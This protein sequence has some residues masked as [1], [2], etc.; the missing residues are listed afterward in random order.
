MFHDYLHKGTN[1]SQSLIKIQ[2][3]SFTKMH[4]KISS[5]KWQPFCPWGDELIDIRISY[6][7]H[8]NGRNGS[9]I[10]PQ[11]YRL[12]IRGPK[13]HSTSGTVWMNIYLDF[14]MFS[15]LM[16]IY[17]VLLIKRLTWKQ[18][19]SYNGGNCIV[20]QN[21]LLIWRSKQICNQKEAVCEE[22]LI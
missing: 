22:K 6:Y 16:L 7:G 20:W 5:A 4:M 1:F 14:D 8:S 18:F 2:N 17:R 12:F 21:L 19:L 3:F 9:L 11:F 15:N 13:Q 10:A